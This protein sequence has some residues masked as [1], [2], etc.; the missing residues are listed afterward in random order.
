MLVTLPDD[1]EFSLRGRQPLDAVL[2]DQ[3]VFL[4]AYVAAARH[5]Y[6]EL[7]CEHVTCLHD[8]VRGLPVAVPARA[9]QSS[10]VVRHAPQAVTQRVLVLVVALG[11]ESSPCSLV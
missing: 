9:E 8:A 7:Q 11:A 10:A 2:C 4:E 5:F 1:P 3:Y 6:S